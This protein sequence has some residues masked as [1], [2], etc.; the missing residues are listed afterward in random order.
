MH[1]SLY[2][3]RLQL[4]S[5]P[6]Q[7]HSIHN[8]DI[9]QTKAVHPLLSP[10]WKFCPILFRGMKLKLFSFRAAATCQFKKIARYM[11]TCTHACTLYR[12]T[13]TISPNVNET[14]LASYLCMLQWAR[15]LL[16]IV[17]CTYCTSEL[18]AHVCKTHK[19]HL[20][21]QVYC[22][23]WLRSFSKWNT[24]KKHL[25]RGWNLQIRESDT[26]AHS[27]RTHTTWI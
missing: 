5:G 4:Q 18:V 12:Y 24:F 14:S 26:S 3:S 2:P 23:S 22:A 9:A 13:C 19:Y 17:L 6:L 8:S 11:R 1:K 25:S 16:S 10:M 15:L 21:F 20:N 27:E 7:K